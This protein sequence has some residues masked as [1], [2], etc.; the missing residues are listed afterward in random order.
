[1]RFL[2]L[3]AIIGMLSFDVLRFG[4][5]FARMHKFVRSRKVS[6][7]TVPPDAVKRVCD[8]VNYACVWYPKVVLCLQRSAVTTCLLRSYDVRTKI[9]INT[10]KIPF[11]AH[12]WTEV[13]GHAINERRDV[14]RDY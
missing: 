6:N 13:D 7:R 11:K 1:M 3:K 14:Q 10:Q 2:I 4:R 12:A 9:I 5:N 8:A